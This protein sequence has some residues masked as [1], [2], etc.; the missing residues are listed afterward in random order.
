[1]S[2]N[3]IYNGNFLHG[4]DSWTGNGITVSNGVATL[5]GDIVQNSKYLVPVATGR[6]YRLTYDLK[7]NTIGGTNAFYIALRPFDNNKT[8]I[9]INR[10]NKVANTNTTLAAELKNGDTTAVLTSSAN[11]NT[12][13]SHHVIGICDQK[14]WDYGRARLVAGYTTGTISNNTLTLSSAWSQGTI[15]AGT[16]VACFLSGSTYCYP[17][18]LSNA[19]LPTEWTTYTAEFNGGNSMRYSCQYFQ[20]STLG[21]SHNYSIRNIKIECISDYQTI[22]WEKQD[23]DIKKTGIIEANHFN[24]IGARIRYVRDWISGNTVNTSNHW[25]EF[26]IINSVGENIA[27]GKDIKYGAN[28]TQNGTLTNSVATDGIVDSQ[29]IGGTGGTNGWGMIDLGYVE[30]IHKVHIWH[31]YSDGRTYYNNKVEV[32]ADGT[33]WWTIYTGQKP[34]TAAGN[35]I[36]VTN[37]Q[38]Q[39]Y[40]TGEIKANQFYEI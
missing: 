38:A 34:E 7:I 17:H 33:N 37:S 39:I 21:Y 6:R 35:E 20:F 12:A 22:D 2:T 36:L 18:Y 11:W 40:R 5:T 25:N 4:T 26:K 10:T 23:S 14:A 3:L 32:S 24:E 15:P 19:N 16:K 27:W 31:Y 29:W 28:S 30:E 8:S 9:V 1:M 13:T